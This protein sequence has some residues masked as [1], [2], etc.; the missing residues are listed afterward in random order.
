MFDKYFKLPLRYEAGY[1][2][3][4]TADGKMAFSWAGNISESAK[5]KI[6]SQINKPS[7]EKWPLS[8]M[9]SYNGRCHVLYDK[10]LM[11]IIRGW[12]MLTGVGGY[13]LDAN[14]AIAIQNEFASFIVE[15]LNKFGK[16]E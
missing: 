15:Q 12:G 8:P 9:F 2:N 14:T 7:Q 11:L 4:C 10:K 1:P 3:V 13:S 16:D 5:K 6:V